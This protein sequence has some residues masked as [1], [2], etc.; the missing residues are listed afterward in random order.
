MQEFLCALED[1]N[2]TYIGFVGS[3]FTWERGRMTAKNIGEPLDR[4]VVTDTWEVLFPNFK[5]SHLIHSM[6]DHCPLLLNTNSFNDTSKR[7]HFRF[8]SSW[9][10]EDSCEVEVV[11]LWNEVEGMLTTKLQHVSQ[12]LGVWDIITAFSHRHSSSR[13]RHNHIDYLDNEV[14]NHFERSVVEMNS[15]ARAYFME[16]FSLSVID[17]DEE[18]LDGIHQNIS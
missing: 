9:L 18:I 14:G 8:Y 2:L 11:K 7:W 17:I 13:K 1:C 12:G 5:L 15:Y 10:L 6:S 3:W 4:G 16:L